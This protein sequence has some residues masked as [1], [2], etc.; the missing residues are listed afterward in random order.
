MQGTITFAD[1]R[2]ANLSRVR[3]WH[4]WKGVHSWD[5]NKWAIAMVGEAGELCNVVK[6]LNR[7]EEGLTGNKETE[8][9]LR[10]MLLKEIADVAIY[11]DLLAASQ[12]IELAEAIVW[13]FNEVSERNGFPERLNLGA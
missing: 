10:A 5:L 13:K 8:G 2:A 4:G 1:L 12:G 7:V 3:K 9:E 11:L 6:K